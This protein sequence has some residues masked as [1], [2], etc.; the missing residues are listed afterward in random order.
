MDVTRLSGSPVPR[1]TRT[2]FDALDGIRGIAALAV[3]L[4]HYTQFSSLRMLP[5][6]EAAVD[7]FFMLSGF[8][9]MF[10]YGR[11][12]ERG[13]GFREFL[14]AR[15]QRLGPLFVIG[16]LLGLTAA[17]IHI[18]RGLDDQL[19]LQ[20]VLTAFG[21]NLVVLPYLNHQ[22]WMFDGQGIPG[23][24]FPLN[25][26]SWSLFFEMFVNLV[27]FFCLAELVRRKR[28]QSGLL[29]LTAGALLVFL[30]GLIHSQQFNGGW[31]IGNFKYGFPRVTAEF[32]LGCLIFLFHQRLPRAYPWLALVSLGLFLLFMAHP[33]DQTRYAGLFVL[34][35]A[36][37]LLM[38]RV[39]VSGALQRGCTRLGELSYP[40]YVTHFPIYRLLY[41]IDAFRTASD[42][43]QLV[44]AATLALTTATL[45][46]PADRWLR[47]LTMMPA[48]AMAA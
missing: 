12:I 10:S 35:P 23:P 24:I 39:S 25:D 19:R 4:Y 41:E 2:R 34:C 42:L 21:L 17:L 37:I 28:V 33:G 27:F 11:K 18:G 20:P 16:L 46:I 36:L 1:D 29:L 13:M 32:F 40:L 6:A 7:L 44:V 15:L 48:S 5:G 30:A 14:L 47:S 9:L 8:V 3:M 45:L 31:G 22:S 26:P 43:A 38:S